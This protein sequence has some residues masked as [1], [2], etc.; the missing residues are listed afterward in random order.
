MSN[1]RM[2]VSMSMM[3]IFLAGCGRGE[4]G[5]DD[6]IIA[7]IDNYE[8]TAGDF[9]NDVQPGTGKTK[10][11]LLDELITR[12]VLLAEAQRQDF[13]KD[14]AFMKEIESYWELALLK[15]LYQK[16]SKEFARDIQIDEREVLAEYAGLIEDYPDM[17]AEPMN[18]VLAELREEQRG[19]KLRQ[20]IDAWI[21]GLR[22]RAR[23]KIDNENLAM[24]NID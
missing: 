13:D 1:M 11:E 24:V 4:K 19:E 14:R 18:E 17:A 3:F 6:V 9:K 16:K 8:M 21:G 7:K 20:A 2:F 23:I 12:K 5:P 10:E 22:S 15:L